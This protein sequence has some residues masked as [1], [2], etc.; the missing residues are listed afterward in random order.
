MSELGNVKHID[1]LPMYNNAIGRAIELLKRSL[2]CNGGRK[3][4]EIKFNDD[5]Y[6]LV[7]YHGYFDKEQA[8]EVGLLKHGHVITLTTFREKVPKIILIYVIPDDD[9][10]GKGRGKELVDQFFRDLFKQFDSLNFPKYRRYEITYSYIDASHGVITMI[11]LKNINDPKDTFLLGY[12]YYHF[13]NSK[14]EP[15]IRIYDEH[16]ETRLYHFD[17]KYEPTCETYD[18]YVKEYLELENIVQH[19]FYIH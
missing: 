5:S 1:F 14:K 18:V 9:N 10:E 8:E 12:I 3:C 15:I 4:V 7:K 13:I 19:I 11:D 16:F 6:I 17:V 2:T